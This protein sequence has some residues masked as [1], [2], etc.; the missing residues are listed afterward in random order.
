MIQGNLPTDKLT[1]YK[2]SQYTATATSKKRVEYYMCPHGLGETLAP[3]PVAASSAIGM[4][5]SEVS[6]ESHESGQVDFVTLTY[7]WQASSD[8]EEG[9]G[10]PGSGSSESRSI[11]IQSSLVEE[12]ITSHPKFRATLENLDNGTLRDLSA[13]MT[14]QLKDETGRDLVTSVTQK[15]GAIIVSKILRGQTKYKAPHMV[16]TITIPGVSTSLPTAGKIS[17][18]PGLP[19]LPDGQRW[20]CDSA[21]ITKSNGA[22]VTKMQFS[23]ANW[24]PDFYPD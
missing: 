17:N 9:E 4:V 10:E 2:P 16:A 5:L 18:Y 21:A 1:Y 7:S 19:A 3:K 11:E 12:P 15:C 13:L 8:D 6:V 14:G 24:D 22:K 20:L 23:A